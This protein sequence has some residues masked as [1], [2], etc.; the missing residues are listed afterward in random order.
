MV[1]GT[2]ATRDG[3]G[4]RPPGE[5][6]E[7]GVGV[8]VGSL[9]RGSVVTTTPDTTLRAAS[10]TMDEHS[11]GSIVVLDSGELAGI[12]TERDLLRA[13]AVDADL[14]TVTVGDR[15]TREVVTAAA[16][17]EVYEAAAEMTDQH[18]RHLVVTAGREV[19]GVLSVRDLL[20]SGQR[21]ELTGGAW[22]VLRDPLTF[23][24]RERRRLQKRLIE[25]EAGPVDSADVD[26]VVAV[27][28]GSWSLDEPVPIS[29]GE[30]GALQERDRDMLRAAVRDELPTL[31]RAVQPAPGWRRWRE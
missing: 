11:V 23:S 21:V 28:V 10:R 29:G 26:E 17:W 16:D 6:A 24:V 12:L 9:A 20:L 22:A 8:T 30:L 3:S 13:I 19:I 4:A 2:A 5:V 15:M 18:I 31:Q 7:P 1:A 14:D 27:L 25:L